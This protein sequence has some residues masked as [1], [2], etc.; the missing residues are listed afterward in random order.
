MPRSR[1]SK[2]ITLT[3]VKKKS[4]EVKD[5]HIDKIRDACGKY[6]RVYL[7]STSRADDTHYVQEIRKKLRPGEMIY[8]K[9]KV[10]QLALGMTPAQECKANIHKLAQR[11]SGPCALLF[12]EKAPAD[13]QQIFAEYRPLDYARAGAVATETVVLSKG[14]DTLAKLHHSIE[15][16]LRQL[17]LP[18][19]LREGKIHLLGDHTACKEGQ[20]ITANAAQ[21][22]KLL[23]IKQAEFMLTVEAHWKKG[24][25][26]VGCDMM[27]D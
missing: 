21:V 3:V 26:C 5:K 25:E 1:R 17:G 18:T 10:M 16:S 11:V 2:V 4:R 20:E 15:V 12:T 6:S 24:G 8:A 22:L 14:P 9:N 7:I 23:E 13:I 19:Q 27:E